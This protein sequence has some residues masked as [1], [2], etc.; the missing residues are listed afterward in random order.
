LKLDL[1]SH[2]FREAQYESDKYKVDYYLSFLGKSGWGNFTKYLASSLTQRWDA[3][4]P[5]RFLS[6]VILQYH[7]LKDLIKMRIFVG[8]SGFT[9]LQLW[10]ILE[11]DFDVAVWS[12][13]DPMI[14]L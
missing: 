3:L 8:N 13:L 6:E 14:R 2:T 1:L 9:P 12:N 10:E 11:R 4:T 5:E 7:T